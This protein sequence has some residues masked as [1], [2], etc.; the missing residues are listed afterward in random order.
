MAGRD[1]L[2]E[3]AV[4]EEVG[5]R[6]FA[7]HDVRPDVD[8]HR[9]RHARA[10]RDD[11]LRQRAPLPVEEAVA[12]E[13]HRIAVLHDRRIR[14]AAAGCRRLR[15]H[16]TRAR[17]SKRRYRPSARDVRSR[18]D[19]ISWKSTCGSRCAIAFIEH[20]E[21]SS[22]S[23]RKRTTPMLQTAKHGQNGVRKKARSWQTDADS[24]QPRASERVSPRVVNALGWSSL[25]VGLAIVGA[26]AVGVFAA[27]RRG[28]SG[29]RAL[30][31]A[32]MATGAVGVLAGTALEVFGAVRKRR[33]ASAWLAA[34]RRAPR[35]R[36]CRSSPSRARP[37]EVYAYWRDLRESPALHEAHGIGRRDRRSP[38][39]LDRAG[40]RRILLRWDA[41][42]VAERPERSDR[43]ALA[44]G[45]RRELDRLGAVRA[46]SRAAAARRSGS[47]SRY[48]APG[49]KLGETIA[50]LFGKEP[51]QLAYQTTATRSSRCSRSA[52]WSSPTRASTRACT[53]RAPPDATRAGDRPRRR[54]SDESP[55]LVRQQG[56]QRRAGARPADPQPR[57]TRSSKVTSTAI[58]GS[59]LHLY[60]GFMPTMEKGDILGHEFM[61][62]VVEVGAT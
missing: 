22:A 1:G 48:D 38:H 37:E 19:G 42:I 21:R 61:G 40:P 30:L 14:P 2:A 7:R 20:T 56:R 50:K 26:S 5:E 12:D 29:M 3:G 25:G 43:V 47:S 27:R 52:R 60:N 24:L 13:E 62:E 32:G 34:A 39:P 44:P 49:G 8:A 36:R 23:A 41:E 16:N 17:R 53:P 58:C 33:D 35:R 9:R 4:L 15:R 6:R 51:G 57:T 10:E 18:H 11:P 46:R 59:D 55:V 28:R 45:R 31:V 54:R